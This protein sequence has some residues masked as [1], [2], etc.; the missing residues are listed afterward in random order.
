M[1]E[2]T[3]ESYWS[4]CTL[5]STLSAFDVRLLIFPLL[6]T[7]SFDTPHSV[8]EAW[9]RRSLTYP[10][11]RNY[12]LST[13][14]IKDVIKMLKTKTTLLKCLADMKSIVDKN[15]QS[16]VLGKMYLDDYVV[17]IQHAEY[18][19]LNSNFNPNFI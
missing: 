1:G 16:Y 13:Q 3:V 9:Y 14:C 11:Y 18:F 19:L 5:S 4:L 8:L 6:T 7:K 2:S 12:A 17:W 10:L 15:D